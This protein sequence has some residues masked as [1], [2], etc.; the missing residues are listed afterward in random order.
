VTEPPEEHRHL[1]TFIDADEDDWAWRRRIRS[2]PTTA[3]VYRVVVFV[4]GLVLVL[5]GLALVPLPG[6]GWLVVI[7]GLVVWA[8]E[9]ERAQIVLDWVKAKVNAWQDWIL[10][11]SLWV[12]VLA[13]FVT[14][15][16]VCAVVWV[17]LRVSGV[18]AFLPDGV[19]TWLRDVARL[20]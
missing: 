18:P 19:E 3:V 20:G 5:G 2:N 17:V 11:Q 13:A 12:R 9:F 14:F 16:F 8:S 4:V 7:L 15:A 6:P 10:A 1:G